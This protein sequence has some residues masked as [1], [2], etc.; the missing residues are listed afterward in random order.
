MFEVSKNSLYFEVKERKFGAQHL[1]I[2]PKGASD[3]LSFKIASILLGEPRE[4]KCVEILFGAEITFTKDVIFT[5]NGA[6]FKTMHLIQD[7]ATLQI[8]HSKVYSAHSGDTLHVKESYIGFRLYLF[9]TLSN[10]SNIKRVGL[11]R[12]A[13]NKYFTPSAQ[14]IRL[15]RGAE[16]QVLKEPSELFNK[17]WTISPS[18]SLMGIRLEGKTLEAEHYDIISSVVDDGT[19]QLT[20][21]GPIILMRHRQTTGGYPRIYQVASVDIDTLA[22]HCVGNFVEFEEISLEEAKALHVKRMQEI[23]NFKNLYKVYM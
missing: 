8:E 13:Y 5:L 6:H 22:Q 23:E 20:S 9:A 4:F 1:G 15:I 17:K 7:G 21:S 18:S 3:Q 10:K 11:A 2:S 16:Y 12:G 19:I 14:K